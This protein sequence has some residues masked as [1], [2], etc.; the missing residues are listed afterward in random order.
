MILAKNSILNKQPLNDS[1]LSFITQALEING[2]LRW[3]I[4]ALIPQDKEELEYFE[5]LKGDDVLPLSNQSNEIETNFVL[6]HV[7]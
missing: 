7:I 1:D 6:S 4:D 2:I 3:R 5:N